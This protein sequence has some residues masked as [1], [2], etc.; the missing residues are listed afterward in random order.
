MNINISEA[1][2][3]QIDWLV[4]N[5]ENALDDLHHQWFEDHPD[6]DENPLPRA[7]NEFDNPDEFFPSTDGR[8]CGFI[9]RR[10]RI[11]VIA[12]ESDNSW[13]AS[14]KSLSS[15]TRTGYGPTPEMAAMR[16]YLLAQVGDV[17]VVPEN[18]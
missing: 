2:E 7:T 16:A 11:S 18:L 9:V 15:Y 10:Q 12:M 1:T 8:Q 6:E 3:C 4:A 14:C 5:C 13:M 17:V